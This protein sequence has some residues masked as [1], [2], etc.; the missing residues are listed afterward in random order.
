MMIYSLVMAVFEIDTFRE[1][2]YLLIIPILIL[3]ANVYCICSLKCKIIYYNK[4]L[5]LKYV[6]LN[7]TIDL[8]KYKYFKIDHTIPISYL[9]YTDN[10]SKKIR[11]HYFYAKGELFY[12]YLL[13]NLEEIK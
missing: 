1:Q 6:I 10:K 5:T 12:K 11:I 8:G 7:K 3:F 13:N 9:L 4:T 2:K